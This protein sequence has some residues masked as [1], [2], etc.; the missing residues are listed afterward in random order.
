MAAKRIF[1]LCFTI[2]GIILLAPVFL[3]LIIWIKLDTK[4]PVFFRQVRVGQSGR[5]FR[6]FKFR[7]MITDAENF[8]KK[9]TVGDDQRIT[10][11]GRIIRKYKLD[12]LPQLFN[13]LLGD[14]SLVGPRPEVP[15]Y[16]EKY[17]VGIKE[18][19]L[20]VPPGIT[21]L[22]SILYKDEST[23]LGTAADP[24]KVYIEQVIPSKLAYYIQYVESRNIWLDFKLILFTLLAIFGNGKGVITKTD[25]LKFFLKQE[26]Y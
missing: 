13:V 2:P 8:G 7:T 22:A 20:S 26:R 24:E 9:I 15:Q 23:L 6:I 14:M 21:D 17:P 12:E 19:V 1:D 4:G 25:K 11:S 10:R 16:V 18:K 3:V 5:I